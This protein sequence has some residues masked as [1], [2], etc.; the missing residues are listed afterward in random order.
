MKRITTKK[1][2][3]LALLTA[4]SFALH[5]IDTLIPS[6]VP[7]PGFRIGLSNLITLFT[8][9]YFGGFS[10]LFVVITK[11][12]LVATLTSGFSIQFLMSLSGSIFSCLI[13]LL[14]YYLIKP[15]SYTISIYSSVFH[16]L[17]QLIVY[18]LFFQTYYI[19]TFLIYLAPV[20]ILSGALIAFLDNILIKRLPNT[21]LEE[22]KKR[23]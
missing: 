4:L 7:I 17:G 12:L 1:L 14:L 18:A 11:S 2:V 8:L 15:C 20:G 19:F 6:F 13:T 5:Y 3:I 9:Y 10:Y 21:F 23:R 16:I 22:D